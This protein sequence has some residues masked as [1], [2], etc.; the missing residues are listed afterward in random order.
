MCVAL[1]L[2]AGLAD[3]RRRHLQARR[4]GLQSRT[5]QLWRNRTVGVRKNIL[6]QVGWSRVASAPTFDRMSQP[7]PGAKCETLLELGET[8]VNQRNSHRAR[9]IPPLPIQWRSSAAVI[10]SLAAVIVSLAM[11]IVSLEKKASVLGDREAVV[12]AG[13]ADSDGDNEEIVVGV[14]VD[15]GLGESGAEASPRADIDQARRIIP[16]KAKYDLNS[17]ADQVERRKL[18]RNPSPDIF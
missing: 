2:V 11:E 12:T 16:I 18:S 1:L 13:K 15:I 7:N 3:A 8:P 14:E 4:V 9:E 10:V 17:I 5:N 6:A